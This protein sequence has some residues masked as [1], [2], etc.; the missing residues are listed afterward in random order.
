MEHA[1]II[2]TNIVKKNTHTVQ[3]P[4]IQDP[5]VHPPPHTH[6]HTHYRTS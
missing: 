3:N 5:Y 6:T 2:I 1:V 4:H